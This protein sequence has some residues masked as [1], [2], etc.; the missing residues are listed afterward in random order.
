MM[1]AILAALL[2]L[3]PAPR[4]VP[5]EIDEAALLGTWSMDWGHGRQTC[6]FWTDG[7][8]WSPEC[9]GGPWVIGRGGRVEFEEGA[10]RYVMTIVRDGDGFAGIGWRTWEDGTRSEVAVR[11]RPKKDE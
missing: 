9:G 2:T 11:L 7:C 8:Y 1:S 6:H 10:T 5:A 3:V 4:V